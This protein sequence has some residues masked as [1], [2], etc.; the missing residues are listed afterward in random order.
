MI[1]SITATIPCAGI[2]YCDLRPTISAKTIDEYREQL[3]EVGRLAGNDAFV[4]RMIQ[5]KA[6]KEKIVTDDD[7]LYFD[8]IA[9]TYEDE[10]GNQF[11]TGS[12]FAHA[13]EKPFDPQLIAPKVAE[14]KLT[15]ADKVI[16]SWDMKSEVSLMYG[17]TVHK[18][19]E[20][21]IKYNELPNNPHLATL[22][23]TYLD[24]SHDEEQASELFVVDMEHKMCGTIDVL[25]NKGNKHVVIRD[26]KGL[27]LNT[28]I[29]T[30]SGFTTMGE[31]KIG[32][33]L[34][35]GKGNLTQVEA[36]SEVH[37]KRCYELSFSSGDPVVADYDHRWLTIDLDGKEKIMTTEE[38][39]NSSCA[40][41]IPLTPGIHEAPVD[42]PIDPYLLGV[43]LGD[44]KHTSGE[45]CLSDPNIWDEILERGYSLGP[46]QNDIRGESCEVRSV[47]DLVGKLKKLGVY[48]NKHIPEIY[49]RAS[50]QQR[51][52]LLAGLLDTDGSY[53]KLRNE[54][55]VCTTKEWWVDGLK[56]L[57][58]S[59][60]GKTTVCN[61]KTSGFG[62]EWEAKQIRVMTLFNPFKAKNAPFQLT[63]TAAKK[64][65]FK[66]VT[67]CIQVE[68]VPT[69][70]IKVTSPEH[71]YLFGKDFHVTHNTGDIYKKATLT[72][73]AKK[74]WPELQNKTISIYQLQLSFYAYI[75][76][77]KGYKVD[78]LEIYAEAAE[79][80]QVVKLPVLDIRKA[81]E[82]E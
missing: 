49:L 66:Y 54:V 4:N 75:L 73:Q 78:G 63:K 19:L 5:N 20:C 12:T 22:V 51:K 80:W 13:F 26:F 82:A 34:Y 41:R 31:I 2:Q 67:S 36:K 28:L 6:G 38:I 18:A 65:T 52:D 50:E 7:I 32:D 16:E 21:G 44:G 43:W 40:V 45:L 15:T 9:H 3:A 79:A 25:V 35:D 37:H 47:Y 48:G 8:P 58:G 14:K 72:P 53:N 42:L 59:L 81:L 56:E 71:T 61:Y 33:R 46:V 69:Q 76:T 57:V 27:A 77:N 64:R 29:P 62:Q 55:T 74:L 11:K 60:G 39:A 24:M 68:S 23:Q 70:C 30:P 17:S 10:E 1:E